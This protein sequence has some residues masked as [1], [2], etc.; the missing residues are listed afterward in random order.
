MDTSKAASGEV[1]GPGATVSL[2]VVCRML[3]TKTFFGTYTSTGE[4]WR[5][6]DSTTAVYWCLDT[7]ETAGPDDRLAHPHGCCPGRTCFKP[8]LE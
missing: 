1:P 5:T 6:G 8:E 3:R 2:P 7:M 4:D